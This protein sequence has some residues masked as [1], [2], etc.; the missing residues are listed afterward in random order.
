M[1]AVTNSTVLILL[2]KINRL[3]LL[4]I[5][6]KIYTTTEIKNEVLNGKEIPLK[7]KSEL[8]NFFNKQV[9]IIDCDNLIDFDLESGENSALSLC[10]HIKINTFLCDDKK[11]RQKADLLS[12]KSIGTLGIILINLREK[13]IS[14]EEAKNILNLLVNNSYYLATDVYAKVLELISN[15]K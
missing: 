1:E 11:A 7:E 15:F 13:R 3:N 9:T 8:E 5:L 14:K 10:S 6:N 12:I 4:K 2:A